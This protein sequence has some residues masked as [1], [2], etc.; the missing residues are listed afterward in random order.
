MLI[1][2]L[3]ALMVIIDDGIKELGENGVRLSIRRVDTNTGIMILQTGLNDV[4]ESGA[5][6]GLSSLE[7]IKD[8]LR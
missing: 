3:E 6:R 4:Q 8:F 7:L 2:L 5:E 1:S